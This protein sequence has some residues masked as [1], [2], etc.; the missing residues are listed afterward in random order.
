MKSTLKW[1]PL[2]EEAV[3]DEAMEGALVSWRISEGGPLDFR[4]FSLDREEGES[5]G[6]S[7]GGREERDVERRSSSTDAD[8][9]CNELTGELR[10]RIEITFASETIEGVGTRGGFGRGASNL[11]VSFV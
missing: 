10:A 1:E 8:D 11:S 5:G 9:D 7:G 3:N 6:D 2:G 4:A